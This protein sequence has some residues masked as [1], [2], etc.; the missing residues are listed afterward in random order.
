MRFW[1]VSTTVRNPERI[2]SFL[3]VLKTIEGECWNTETQKKFQVLL[4]KNKVYGFGIPQFYNSLSTEH[5]NWLD[6]PKITYTQAKQI[7]DAKDYVGGGDMRGRQSFN[8]I[9]KMGLTY[10]DENNRIVISDFGNYFLKDDYDLGDVFFKSFL[11][12]QYPNPDANKY[13]AENGYNIKPF[14][15]CLHII[16]DVNNIC[17]DKGLKIKGISRIEFA[18]FLVSLVNYKDISERAKE[19]VRFRLNFEKIKDRNKQKE[20]IE[21]YFLSYF[22]EFESWKNANEYTDNIIRYFRLTRYLYIRGNGWYVDLEPRRNVE[23]QTLINSDNASAKTF[24]RRIDYIKYLCNP[25]EPIL[26]WETNEKLIEVINEQYSDIKILQK[27]VLEKYGI[28]KTIK[29]LKTNPNLKDLKEYSEYL[30]S[31][32]R[33]LL[34]N[35]KSKESQNIIKVKEYISLL[36]DIFEIVKGRPVELERSISLGLQALNDALEIK[37]NYPVGDD[38][39][40][41]FTAPANKP[42]IECYYKSFNSICE[43]TLL[44]NR[45]QWY[46]EGQPVMRHI[47]DFEVVNPDKEIYCLFIAPRLHR[48]TINTFWFSVKYEYEGKKQKIVPLTITQFVDLLKSLIKWKKNNIFLTHKQIKELYKN[49]VELTDN[50]NNSDEWIAKIPEVINNWKK[51]IVA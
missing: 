50:V 43:V 25:D 20:Y 46:N 4:I 17:Y 23:I 7:L 9:E 29:E 34:N 51:R 35:A 2:R 37:P 15:A 39:E 12:W 45:T 47:R 11:K 24:N 41:T 14:I 26:P 19:I 27:S 1:S 18:L 32:R 36:E 28:I 49:V 33:T 44:T 31:I 40:P 38:N 6:D 30:R 42:D 21:D 13:K 8:P 22:S 48:D 10:L 5:Q 3:S 16:N